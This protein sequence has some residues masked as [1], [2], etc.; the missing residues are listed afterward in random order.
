MSSPSEIPAAPDQGDV[1]GNPPLGTS[2]DQQP[3]PNAAPPRRFWPRTIRN[4]L[5][6]SQLLLISL[7]VVG[8]G[9]T[10][11]W[12]VWHG[13]YRQAEADL[14]GAAQV[15]SNEMKERAHLPALTIAKAYRHRFGPAPRD[16]AYFA[17][18][19]TQGQLI[20]GSDP[21]PPHTRP[22][23]QKPPTVGPHPFFS[24][25]HG[26]HLEVIISG[27]HGEQV[28]VGRPL[29]R[30][31]DGL[32][33]LTFAVMGFGLLSLAAGAAG[34]WQL[35]RRIVRP[36]E[37]MTHTAEQI[38]Y[39]HLDERLTT[40]ATS[41][42]LIRLTTVFNTMLD[43]LQSSFQQQ[44]RFTA[45]ASHELRTP[46]AVIL[47]QA[48]HSLSRPRTADEYRIALETCAAAANRMRRLI[49][50]LLVLA[51]AD[52][53]RLEL[54]RIPLD[55]AEVVRNTA[56]M[57]EPLAAERKVRLTFQ[58]LSAMVEG[59][60]SRLGQVITNLVTNAIR[61]NRPEG[62]VFVSVSA[63]S[64][65]LAGRGRFGNW[66]TDCGPAPRVRAILSRR[67]GPHLRRES[68][69]RPG[70]EY[71]PGNR[72]CPRRIYGNCLSTGSRDDRDRSI[73]PDDRSFWPMTTIAIVVVL[74][75]ISNLF[76]TYAWY[77]HLKDL[78]QQ[79][80]Y[81]AVL[82]SWG[83]AF[84]EYLVQVPANRYGEAH[85]LQLGQLKILQEVVTLSVFVPFAVF[86]M[87][88]PLSWNFAYA[89]LCLCGAVYFVFRQ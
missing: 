42:E 2:A 31:I 49:D 85:N 7:I 32:R 76:M 11:V 43:R 69:H 52:L 57:L 44:T 68:G 26:P 48:E 36:L 20:A 29:A 18:W 73:A 51:R 70:V 30:E 38:S 81:I 47:T 54:K 41:R 45:D 58:L 46:V 83:I 82:V 88:R 13:I 80:W 77:G 87:Q 61:Y 8:F 12:L 75:T 34:A 25:I 24:R 71:C 3:T 89:G 53:G 33:R 27:P 39:R 72:D 84:F 74:L 56:T 59:D 60:P 64:E 21:L 16:H 4:D 86:Y 22:E 65:D 14:L 5:L 28:L 40:E 10:I 1:S 78:A 37:Q 79:P 23:P 15:L 9:A 6:V 66:H 67:S 17:V 35:A 55:L 50:D 62:D 19:D 63:R